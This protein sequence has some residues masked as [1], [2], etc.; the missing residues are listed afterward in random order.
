MVFW[1]LIFYVREYISLFVVQLLF[2]LWLL[3]LLF[4]T[5]YE[6]R[7]V[8]R[9]ASLIAITCI[10]MTFLMFTFYSYRISVVMLADATLSRIA[11][12]EHAHKGELI[13]AE[14]NLLLVQ[15]KGEW[16]KLYEPS[17]CGWVSKS[18]VLKK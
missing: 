14:K 2:L 5:F 6:R 16:L 9:S 17:V 15:E 10:F 12:Y 13:P 7:K 1:S 4:L 11:P 18:V 3:Y 8:G